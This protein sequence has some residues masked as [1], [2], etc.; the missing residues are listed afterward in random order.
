MS[1]TNT[2]MQARLDRIQGLLLDTYK[3][4][5]TVISS[6][7]SLQQ[8]NMSINIKKG[9]SVDREVSKL[10]ATD[11]EALTKASLSATHKSAYLIFDWSC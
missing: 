4:R 3:D 10:F 11:F 7:A 5:V 1:N 8:H 9:E 2:L 6:D